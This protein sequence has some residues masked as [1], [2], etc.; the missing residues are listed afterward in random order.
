MRHDVGLRTPA[1]SRRALAHLDAS[2]SF[3]P[4]S[5]SQTTISNREL[6]P[7]THLKTK[8]FARDAFSYQLFAAIYNQQ[9][10]FQCCMRSSQPRS[11]THNPL[12]MAPPL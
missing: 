2:L 7:P 6:F 1:A 9:P 10:Q 4:L 3:L 11:F 12:C 5:I 8:K